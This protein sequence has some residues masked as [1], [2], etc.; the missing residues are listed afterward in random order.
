M[1]LTR[2]VAVARALALAGARGISGEALAQELGVSRVAV[3][4][5]IAA[6]RASGY[7]IASVH[8]SGY[9]LERAP[10]ACLPEEVAWRLSDPLWVACEGGPE[11][12]STNDDA[13]RL[14]RDGAPEGT[15]VVAAR[16]RSG[17][18]RFDRRWES[19]AGGVYA[20]AILRPALAPMALGPLGLVAGLGAARALEQMGVPVRLK[21][22]NDIIAEG[23]KVAGVL[24]EMAAEA[25]R[26]EW[27]VVG[28][29][30]NVA[31]TALAD[32]AAVREWAPQAGV[33]EVAASVLDGVAAAYREFVTEGFAAL[34]VEYRHRCAVLGRSVTVRDALGEVRAQGAAL[35]VDDNGALVVDAGGA[36]RTV[37]AGEVTLR[38]DVDESIGD[39][40]E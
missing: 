19:P 23:R 40:L 25:D 21:W 6:L 33:A 13:K 18:G 2:R 10:D 3:A 11:T 30:V 17:R 22:P 37:V 8:G 14:A 24:V 36:A 4:K 31:P 15:L 28:I 1:M 12:D 39:A 32:T 34:A 16:Q 38:P 35:T 5:H 26:V 9:R 27:V 29:G 20:S 7:T